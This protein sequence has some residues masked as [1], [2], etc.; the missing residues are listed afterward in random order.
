MTRQLAKICPPGCRVTGSTFIVI[1]SVPHKFFFSDFKDVIYLEISSSS[2]RDISLNDVAVS[3][4]EYDPFLDSPC[5]ESGLPV[6][7][8]R[9]EKCLKLIIA[10]C[11]SIHGAI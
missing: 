4:F 10:I 7:R 2:F 9:V 3:V 6:P 11:K 8:T 1:N 5:A